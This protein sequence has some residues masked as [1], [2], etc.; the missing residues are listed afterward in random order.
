MPPGTN[1]AC[2]HIPERGSEQH[3]EHA[4][5]LGR[6]LGLEIGIQVPGA[7][8]GYQGAQCL[9]LLLEAGLLRGVLVPSRPIRTLRS[10]TRYRKTQI[11]DRRCARPRGR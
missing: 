6:V 5:L 9:Y 3:D 8:G 1:N 4:R 2:V 7:Q 11:N 10:L